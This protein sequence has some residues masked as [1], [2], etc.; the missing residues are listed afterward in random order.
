[1]RKLSHKFLKMLLLCFICLIS[2]QHANQNGR[3]G[4][5]CLETHV[6]HHLNIFHYPLSLIMLQEALDDC[7]TC[8]IVRW[9]IVF[10]NFLK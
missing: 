8:D 4:R 5:I 6:N 9:T 7:V 3:N 2:R 1:M 10:L